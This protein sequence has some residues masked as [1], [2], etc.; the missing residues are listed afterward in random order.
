LQ[1][2]A[3]DVERALGADERHQRGDAEAGDRDR[4]EHARLAS[5]AMKAAGAG[6]LEPP[7]PASAA[8]SFVDIG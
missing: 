1:D 7:A 3:L 5:A 2:L 4:L 8:P 6:E